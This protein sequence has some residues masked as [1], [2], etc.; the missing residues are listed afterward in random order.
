MGKLALLLLGVAIGV[1][2]A[3]FVSAY[4]ARQPA[5]APGARRDG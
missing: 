3:V 5:G 4:A 2:A 1:T